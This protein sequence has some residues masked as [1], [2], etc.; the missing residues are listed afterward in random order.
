MK[1]VLTILIILFTTFSLF[2]WKELNYAANNQE[3]V[4]HIS[5][6]L[7]LD[8]T[9]F[10]Y[11]GINE[12]KGL[13]LNINDDTNNFRYLISPTHEPK[14][15][16]GLLI[17]NFSLIS[18]S[19][20]YRLTIS[21]D[22]LVNDDD[23]SIVYDYELCTVYSVLKNTSMI[24]HVVYCTANPD[25][26]VLSFDEINGILMLQDA[27]LYFRLCTEVQDAGLYHST[28]TLVLESLQ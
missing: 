21:H 20:N 28:V 24:E 22:K 7:E 13:N 11:A 3:I 17:A 5:E 23:Y 25:S 4:A 2:A 9:G 1:K 12:G 15:V 19:S 16:P 8:L 6:V 14:S 27:G 10:Y 26:C 18:S